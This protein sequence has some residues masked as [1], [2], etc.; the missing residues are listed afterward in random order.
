MNKPYAQ[1]TKDLAIKKI[2][3]SEKRVP[4]VASELGIS[5]STLYRW[6]KLKR[7]EKNNSKSKFLMKK[8]ESRLE[9]ISEEREVLLKAAS[10]LAREIR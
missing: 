1:D 2:L 9:E 6:I 5:S 8:L 7:E 10:I 4:E 3:N